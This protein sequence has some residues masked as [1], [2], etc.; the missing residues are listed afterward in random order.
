MA[1]GIT[2]LLNYTENGCSTSRLFLEI[3][4]IYNN[5]THTLA[6]THISYFKRE[7]TDDVISMYA[8]IEY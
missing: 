5:L 6:G 8:K 7:V 4:C 3:K 2:R 1:I